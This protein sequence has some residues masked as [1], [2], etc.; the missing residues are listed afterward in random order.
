MNCGST[1]MHEMSLC[2]GIVEILEEQAVAQSYTR[3]K[4]VWLEIGELAGVEVEALRFGFDVT[5][6]GTLAEG[7][8]LETIPLPGTAW[9]LPCRTSVE[10]HQ[11]FDPCPRCGSYQL[12]ITGGEEFRIK[13]LEVE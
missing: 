8:V 13:E 1:E 3:V 5:T 9:C 11:R 12:Q 2:A 10:T 4:T 7:A 6:R